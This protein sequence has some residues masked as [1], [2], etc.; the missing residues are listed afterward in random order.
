MLPNSRFVRILRRAAIGSE[1]KAV[2]LAWWEALLA[3]P[4]GLAALLF[5]VQARF[6]SAVVV[7]AVTVLLG[8]WRAQ[9]VERNLPGSYA[10]VQAR[11]LATQWLAMA[12]IYAV[13]VGI[14]V[15]GTL[16]HWSK[17]RPGLVAV[18]ASA[19]LAFFI[20]RE[21]RS[22]G[23]QAFDYLI[24]SDA[25]IR[26]AECLM[27]RDRGWDVVHDVSKDGKGNV[28][29]IVLGPNVAFAIETK[30]GRDSGRARSQALSSAAWAKEKYG[31]R[32]VN[33]VVCVF[34]DPPTPPT[35]I[36]KAW[37]TGIGDL[38]SLLSRPPATL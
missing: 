7:V 16:N 1:Q 6:V 36:G 27:F 14:L 17:T 20:A 15:V 3:V 30:S 24:G 11:L 4:L 38:E 37:V 32:W 35:K 26:I 5:V 31:R 22:R 9:I 12:A 19:G 28:D 2:E 21:L 34:A 18:Y 33:A 13:I 25:E 29:H 10:R 23:D 8:V